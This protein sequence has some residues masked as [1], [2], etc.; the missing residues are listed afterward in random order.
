MKG[1]PTISFV[2]QKYYDEGQRLSKDPYICKTEDDIHPI[3]RFVPQNLMK[4]SDS[5]DKNT[6]ARATNES[7]LDP[8]RITLVN[9]NFC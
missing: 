5:F 4:Y 1:N 8:S 6:K 9:I 2:S 7:N 3:Y